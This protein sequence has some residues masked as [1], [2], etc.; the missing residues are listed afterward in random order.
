MC[1]CC[2]KEVITITLFTSVEHRCG[3]SDFLDAYY[4]VRYS[5]VNLTIFTP[6]IYTTL[7]D[8]DVDDILGLPIFKSN[9]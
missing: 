2:G 3:C 6:I 1:P 8:I 5:L 4:K 7:P 9:K